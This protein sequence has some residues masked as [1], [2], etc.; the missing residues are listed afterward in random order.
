MAIFLLIYIVIVLLFWLGWAGA[1]TFL[2]LK[3]RLPDN[4]GI[5][6]LAVFWGVSL[7]ILF[8]SLIFILRADWVTVPSFMQFL[9]A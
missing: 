2:L 5:V 6:H 9:G 3:Y 4:A 1:L 8:I 7:F